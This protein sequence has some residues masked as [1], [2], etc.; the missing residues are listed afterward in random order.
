MGDFNIDLLKCELH[1]ETDEFL[2]TMLKNLLR[3]HIIQPTRVNERGNYSLIDNIFY[4][5]IDNNCISGNFMQP[6]TDH[7]SN[8]L[9]I[10]K[11]N[12]QKIFLK[13]TIRD[14][15]RFNKENFIKDFNKM[16]I[17]ARISS[18]TNVNSMYNYFHLHFDKLLDKHIP[19]KTLSNKES[20]QKQ[21]P[22]ITKEI[23]SLIKKKN[24][25]YGSFMKT[26]KRLIYEQYKTIRDH[27][28]HS[29]RKSRILYYKNH[30]DKFNMNIKKLWKGVNTFLSRKI[31]DTSPYCLSNNN[32]IITNPNRIVTIFND[33]FCGIAKELSSKLPNVLG[34]NHS[35]FLNDPCMNSLFLKPI[36]RE[37]VKDIIDGLDAS[38]AIYIYNYP[39]KAIKLLSHVISDLLSIIYNK[40]F[41]S[42]IFP[43]KL[44]LA[45]VISLFKSGI[46][47]SVKNY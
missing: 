35:D 47:T 15:S 33:Y 41:S 44:K 4:N 19:S 43:D 22:W 23:L 5:S 12:F 34:K 45:K 46:R 2:S 30:Y 31:Q 37:N 17:P 32:E 13:K 42:G 39:I 11:M 28:N 26:K 9:I 25:L 29:I 3:P 18:F 24:K 21:K 38:K 6:I 14:F 36:T 20:K 7:L 40:S 8:F 1:E 10:E 27:I 16:N